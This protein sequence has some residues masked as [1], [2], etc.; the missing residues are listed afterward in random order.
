MID[1]QM[2]LKSEEMIDFLESYDLS[3]K[4]HFDRIDEGEEDSYT[5]E[6]EELAL[7]LR[8]NADQHCTTIFLRDPDV[9]EEEGLVSFPNLKTPAE[10]E[11]YAQSQGLKLTRRDSFLRCDGPERVFHYEFNG[12]DLAM[13]TIMASSV[14]P[15]V[16]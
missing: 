16:G 14:A 11:A 3:V 9:V 4:Y 1:I 7:E 2:H 12:N 8:F 13:I 5:V 10:I 6:C 15:P